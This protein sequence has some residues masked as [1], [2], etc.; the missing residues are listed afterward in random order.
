MNIEGNTRKIMLKM[1]AYSLRR[2][3]ETRIFMRGPH[4]GTE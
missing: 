3:K 1:K 4:E 2:T